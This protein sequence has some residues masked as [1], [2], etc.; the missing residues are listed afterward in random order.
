MCTHVVRAVEVD[1]ESR[2]GAEDVR[3]Q[4][5]LLFL[6]VVARDEG[7]EAPLRPIIETRNAARRLPL[8]LHL[9]EHRGALGRAWPRVSSRGAGERSTVKRLGAY[10][11]LPHLHGLRAR[12][13][14]REVKRA[15]I[16][17]ARANRRAHEIHLRT[18]ERLAVRADARCHSARRPERARGLLARRE[19][20]RRRRH[21]LLLA[22]QEIAPQH[23][24][25]R[26]R[27]IDPSTLHAHRAAPAHGAARRP[28]VRT[29][30][31]H[32]SRSPSCASPSAA[33]R[34]TWS[35]CSSRSTSPPRAP[36]AP[37]CPSLHRSRCPSS[38][39]ALHS[40][41]HGK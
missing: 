26:H 14:P 39:R 21:L 6:D 35:R 5:R 1:R 10:G 34:A 27:D 24:A 12:R 28:A 33:W 13:Q 36:P 2:H 23:A 19:R 20:G 15:A 38:S 22:Q 37:A 7:A 4:D 41:C 31:T 17:R 16:V 11:D 40:R 29:A 8:H 9:A 25:R 18:L 30:G 32:R 3:E